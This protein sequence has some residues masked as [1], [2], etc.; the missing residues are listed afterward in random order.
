VLCVVWH[1]LTETRANHQHLQRCLMSCSG[2]GHCCCALHVIYTTYEIWF[3]RSR[4]CVLNGIYCLF[5]ITFVFL[6]FYPILSQQWSENNHTLCSTHCLS[7]TDNVE[8]CAKPRQINFDQWRV[9]F[10]IPLYGYLLLV[11]HLAY[12]FLRWLRFWKMY[13]LLTCS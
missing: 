13:A 12:R 8:G 5:F 4:R 6:E 11:T 1:C 9:M 7:V 3:L 10:L 2:P